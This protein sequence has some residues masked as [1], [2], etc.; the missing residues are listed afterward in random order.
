[1]LQWL[2]EEVPCCDW[3]VNWRAWGVKWR[4][5]GV[6]CRVRGVKCIAWALHEELWEINSHLLRR[7][8]SRQSELALVVAW[9]QRS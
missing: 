8:G 5:W 1:M 7:L 6:K 3:V 9:R 2:A 4:V